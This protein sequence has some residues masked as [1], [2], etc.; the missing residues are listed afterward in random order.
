MERLDVGLRE[1][2][3]P[4]SDSPPFPAR[5][6]GNQPDRLSRKSG[7]RPLRSPRAV[8]ALPSCRRAACRL[9]AWP[10]CCLAA[11]LPG[12]RAVVISRGPNCAVDVTNFEGLLLHSSGRVTCYFSLCRAR[13]RRT[14]GWLP[15]SWFPV[16]GCSRPLGFPLPGCTRPPGLLPEPLQG[17][18]RALPGRPSGQYL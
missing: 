18:S 13:S 7:P 11:W 10:P 12:C 1:R 2:T 17:L 14:L 5:I 15:P 8:F 16:P 3:F 9:V 6:S 4:T